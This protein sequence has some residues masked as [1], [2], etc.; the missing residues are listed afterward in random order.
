MSEIFVKK[1]TLFIDG[2]EYLKQTHYNVLEDGTK[3]ELFSHTA[4]VHQALEPE[5]ET[6]EQ[7][8]INAEILLSNAE[9][10]SKLK[11]QDEVQAEILL[12]QMEV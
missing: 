4:P 9:I 7:E 5:T 3:K 12:N 11:E 6:S 10:L 1:E 2:K 8:I